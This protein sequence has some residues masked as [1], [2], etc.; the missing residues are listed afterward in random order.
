MDSFLIGPEFSLVIFFFFG[1]KIKLGR[2]EITEG[3][4]QCDISSLPP[5]G[6]FYLATLYQEFSW[7]GFLLTGLWARSLS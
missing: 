2:E 5:F 7:L 6:T 4:I 1:E 3:V